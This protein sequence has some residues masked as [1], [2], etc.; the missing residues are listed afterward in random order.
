MIVTKM[1]LINCINYKTYMVEYVERK[2]I[3]IEEKLI[4]NFVI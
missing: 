1:W 3:N 4:Q 2:K